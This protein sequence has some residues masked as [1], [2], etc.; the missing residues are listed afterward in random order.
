MQTVKR[1][2]IVLACSAAL[3][4]GDVFFVDASATGANSGTSW[5]N[6]FTSLEDAMTIAQ[7]GDEIWIA[8]GIYV[9]PIA[10]DS[11][12]LLSGVRVYGGF[13]GGETSIDDRDPAANPTIIQGDRN[14]DDGPDFT[15][16]SD[17]AGPLFSIEGFVPGVTG[18][19]RLDGLIFTGGASGNN[20]N[21]GG[22][23]RSMILEQIDIDIDGCV[24]EDNVA[25]ES[26]GAIYLLSVGNASITNSVFRSNAVVP[27]TLS[28]SPSGGAVQILGNQSS[29]LSISDSLFRDNRVLVNLG[30]N[31]PDSQSGGALSVSLS[32]GSVTLTRTDFLRNDVAG[33]SGGAASLFAGPIDIDRCR[34]LRNG[35]E[36]GVVGALAQG[37]ALRTSGGFFGTDHVV[38][39]ANS[40]FVGNGHANSIGGAIDLF[41]IAA[42][43]LLIA[44]S[45]ITG[46]TGRLGGAISSSEGI[47]IANSTIADN[48]TTTDTSAAL[49]IN[50]KPNSNIT[51]D[52]SILW[53]NPADGVSDEAAQFAVGAGG[54]ITANR[55]IVEGWTGTLPGVV[56]FSGDPLFNDPDGPDNTLGTADD[57][58]TLAPFSPAIDAGING[59][60]PPDV[61]DIDDDGDTTETLPLDLAGNPRRVN[62]P[63]VPNSGA[64]AGPIVDIGAFERQ[65]RSCIADLSSP[66]AP[67]VPDGVLSGADFFQFLTLFAAGDL[68]VD[69]SSPLRPGVRDGVLSGADFFEFLR[70]FNA[71]C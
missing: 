54:T 49:I 23:V 31:G 40:V 57:D 11:F 66:A 12:V 1:A 70:L 34:F 33:G 63:D 36:I 29:H 68:A 43:Q 6:A 45:Q 46:N 4:A 67:G 39:I 3:A 28:V 65:T 26:G 41:T 25:R 44:N 56:S 61:L 69:F 18:T 58:Y 37:G 60:L 9:P 64:G 52:N 21:E 55:S 8:A 5:A 2:S 20:I 51:V 47:S 50:I 15:N 24:F 71:G 22:A 35:T 59:L 19:T 30:P 48:V 53:N 16:R 42:G 14:G 32:T 13:S 10:D 17:N 38:R 7:N 62:D 27:N